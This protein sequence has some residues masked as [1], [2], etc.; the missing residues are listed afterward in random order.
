M[1]KLLVITSVAVLGACS[2]LGD[3]QPKV[4]AS[5]SVDG[6]NLT[7]IGTAAE[8]KDFVVGF[9]KGESAVEACK[10]NPDFCIKAVKNPSGVKC[11]TPKP[12][13]VK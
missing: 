7:F 1:K 6:E 9:A 8:F 12:Y 2:M 5:C 11:D 4:T 13:T 10:A 3:L